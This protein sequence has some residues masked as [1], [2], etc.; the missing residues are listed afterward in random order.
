MPTRVDVLNRMTVL[1]TRSPS[2]SPDFTIA[3]ASVVKLD[4]CTVA[5]EAT[6]HPSQFFG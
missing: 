2:G 5:C 4:L 3:A 6:V 1:D